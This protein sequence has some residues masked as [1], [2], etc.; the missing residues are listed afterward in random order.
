MAECEHLGRT[1]AYFD[2]ALET[3]EH[4][5]A[6]AHLA[7]C[8]ECQGLLGDA[9][10]IDAVLSARTARRARWPF[11]AAG[12]LAVAAAIAV[13]LA[14]PRPAPSRDVAFALPR[15]RAVE[16]RFTAAPFDAHRP[17]DVL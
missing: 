8:A 1:S 7:S 16:A 5:A 17:L 13:W 12:G 6:A 15:A 3:A 2:G 10:G 14:W 11:V 4:D 9:V